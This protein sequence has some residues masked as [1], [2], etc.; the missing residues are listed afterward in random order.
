MSLLRR[1]LNRATGFAPETSLSPPPRIAFFVSRFPTL[2]E[3]FIL[4]QV[5]ALKQAG[6][7]VTV[8]AERP[9]KA[10]LRHDKV[11]L[12]VADAMFAVE[13][14]LVKVLTMRGVPGR[15]KARTIE[16]ARR[17]LERR[18]LFTC[19]LVICHFGPMGLRAIQAASRGRR[20]AIWTFFHGHDVSS[21]I[22]RLGT[23]AYARLFAEGDL[24]LPIS[25][26]WARR[27]EEIGCP[28]DRIKLVRMGVDCSAIPFEPR[29]RAANDP[30][31]ITT[32]G[33][34]VEKKGGE[35]AI[36]AVAGLAKSKPHLDWRL[37]LAGAGPLEEQF[38]DL[39][40]QLDVADRVSF[41]GGLSSSEV[42]AQLRRT[43]IFLLPSVTAANG[44]MEGIPVALME[45]MAAGIP[46]VSTFHSGIP[47]LVEHGISGLLAAERDHVAL[48][49]LL[50]ELIEDAEK[51]KE[52][53]AAARRKV[54][55]VFNQS[56]IYE[57]FIALVL[58][59]VSGR[60]GRDDVR[61]GDSVH[62][63]RPGA[64]GE[65]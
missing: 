39:A 46:V 12:A 27:L 24:F 55:T 11:N 3:T 40:C 50:I 65:A 51:G 17:R 21:Y 9:E 63:R 16:N 23:D 2:S 56:R 4:D 30:V 59:H 15:I 60:Q 53:A 52:L 62:R 29:R 54:E 8:V 6:M 47:E 28:A 33:R 37:D 64:R 5:V 61:R 44:D 49:R 58:N 34:L 18:A 36:R 1:W 45:A 14:P 22:Q 26:H 41:L 19:D 25:D 31:R 32:V 43:D 13:R 42:R 38:R 7:E 20:A 48:T 57:E 10:A 35:Y